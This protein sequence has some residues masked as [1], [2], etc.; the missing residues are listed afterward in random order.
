MSKPLNSD[1]DSVLAS[2]LGKIALD[3]GNSK[4]EDVGDSID[5]G[6]ILRRL[7]EENGFEVYATY[8]LKQKYG[9]SS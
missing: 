8:E 6:L 1:M 3:A 9:I 5:R 4:R 7:L 2:T